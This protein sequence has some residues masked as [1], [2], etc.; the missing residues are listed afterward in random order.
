MQNPVGYTL[1]PETQRAELTDIWAVLTNP[2][3]VTQ[4]PHTMFASVMF[5]ACVL[6]AVAAWHLAWNRFVDEMRTSLRFRALGEHPRLHR[7]RAHR[8]LARHGHD[9]DPAHEDG[10]GRGAL[11]HRLPG[12]TPR[13]RS[14]AG[15]RRT[16]RTRP[17]SAYRTCSPSCRTAPS[18][19]RSR[20]S[21]TCRRSTRR[22]SAAMQPRRSPARAAD[23]SCPSS[24]S[25]TG[26]S[27]G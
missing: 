13:S 1:N 2:V 19:G 17:R 25:P 20:A 9:P 10:G 12:R 23:H 5:A 22:C 27:G 7:G 3:A 24:G 14:S 15:A 8:A 4:F 21:A 18:T 6:V 26:R 11:Q 16:E